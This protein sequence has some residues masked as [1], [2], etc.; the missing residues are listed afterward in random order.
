MR[1]VHHAIVMNI[2]GDIKMC[3]EKEIGAKNHLIVERKANSDNDAPYSE[4][5]ILPN[6]SYKWD[7]I[8]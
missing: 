2:Q 3:K 6:E 5:I 7:F 4:W 1:R 8:L